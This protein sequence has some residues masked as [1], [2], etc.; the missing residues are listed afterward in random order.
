[1]SAAAI[2]KFRSKLER[3]TF[4]TQEEVRSESDNDVPQQ[5]IG[6]LIAYRP[7]QY[8]YMDAI[9]KLKK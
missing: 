3:L 1:M 5:D 2:A 6:V 4:E 9:K 8:S 7:W